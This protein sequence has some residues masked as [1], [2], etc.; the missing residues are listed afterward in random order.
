MTSGRVES[1]G[2]GRTAARAARPR[3]SFGFGGAA[4]VALNYVGV[5]VI[6]VSRGAQ[7]PARRLPGVTHREPRSGSLAGSAATRSVSRR[8]APG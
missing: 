2:A 8:A 6:S 1:D 3:L 7:R 5:S 4:V